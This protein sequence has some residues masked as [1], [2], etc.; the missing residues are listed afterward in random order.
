VIFSNRTYIQRGASITVPPRSA[1][2][3]FG[4]AKVSEWVTYFVKVCVS[5]AD[6][7]WKFNSSWRFQT[8]R[9]N[10]CRKKVNFRENGL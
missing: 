9:K 6:V 4:N 7:P 10:V 1:H 3:T 8:R 5:S 2:G